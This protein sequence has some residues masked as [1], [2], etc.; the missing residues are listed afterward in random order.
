MVLDRA[1]VGR[2]I[3]AARFDPRTRH[4]RTRA[5][6]AGLWREGDRHRNWHSVLDPSCAVDGDVWE[7]MRLISPRSQLDCSR[8]IRKRRMSNLLLSPLPALRRWMSSVELHSHG[9]HSRVNRVRS[10]VAAVRRSTIIA[11]P[12]SPNPLSKCGERH[13]TLRFPATCAPRRRCGLSRP[14]R[15]DPE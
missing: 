9:T 15:S 10:C 14:F 2:G 1:R 13:E 7:A 6:R 11:G 5:D 3:G 8:T 12:A 4:G